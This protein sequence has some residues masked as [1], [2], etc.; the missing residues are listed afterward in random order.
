M[1]SK[2]STASAL[3]KPAGGTPVAMA[4]MRFVE[5]EVGVFR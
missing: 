3:P 1:T 4:E 5:F 2:E